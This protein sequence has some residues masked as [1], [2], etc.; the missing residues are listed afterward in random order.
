ML[1]ADKTESIT[2]PVTQNFRITSVKSR[3]LFSS[4]TTVVG[5]WTFSIILGFIIPKHLNN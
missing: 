2:F 5:V 1:N 4:V 3:K